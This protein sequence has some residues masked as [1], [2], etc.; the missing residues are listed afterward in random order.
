MKDLAGFVLPIPAEHVDRIF[1]RMKKSVIVKNIG[2]VK[3]SSKPLPRLPRLRGYGKLL[4]YI[5]GSG[6]KLAGYA[7]IVSAEYLTPRQALWKYQ[8]QLVLAESELRQYS[9]GKDNKLLLVL[10]F[11]Q[12]LR[13]ASDRYYH[14]DLGLAGEYLSQEVF[15]RI[16]AG[17][18]P[19]KFAS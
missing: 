9:R 19:P 16:A 1:G 5:S 17:T 8:D 18:S 2:S 12:A 6:R 3:E 10:R 14:K 15:D 7:D 4:F 13:F 11:N